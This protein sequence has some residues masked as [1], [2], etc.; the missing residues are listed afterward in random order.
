M[1]EDKLVEICGVK[2]PCVDEG[3]GQNKPVDVVIRPE[4]IRLSET[5][6][7]LLRGEVT[8]LIFK[9]VHYEMEVMAGGHEWLVHSTKSFPVGTQVSLR[10]KPFDIQIMNKP[11]S[12]DE[13]A[14]EVDG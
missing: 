9:G 14:V 5:E 13:M 12:E 7:G 11:A 2:C 1:I 4:D 8:H 3:F 6:E 10:V